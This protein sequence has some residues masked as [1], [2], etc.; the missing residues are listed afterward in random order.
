MTLI[1]S[2]D[3]GERC[4][5]IGWRHNIHIK[6]SKAQPYLKLAEIPI[7]NE[8]EWGFNTLKERYKIFQNIKNY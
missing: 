5:A 4:W 8:K 3:Q 6:S 2:F 1:K 7:R